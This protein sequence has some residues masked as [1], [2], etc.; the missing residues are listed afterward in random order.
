MQLRRFIEDDTPTALG[1]V[2][3]AFGDDAIILANRRVGEQ[4]EIIA[5][6]QLDESDLEGAT[7]PV[8][9]PTAPPALDT[10]L[11]AATVVE[12]PST[13]I[14]N[15]AMGKTDDL[16]EKRPFF[17]E[18]LRGS[19]AAPTVADESTM[20]IEPVEQTVRD[21]SRPQ[22]RTV[23]SVEKDNTTGEAAPERSSSG[24]TVEKSLNGQLDSMF[25][26]L[27]QRFQC[28]EVNLWG[29][30]NDERS[31]LLK[32]LLGL[33]LGARLAVSLAERVPLECDAK[34]GLRQVLAVLKATLP[35]GG[36]HRQSGPGVTL[37]NGPAGGGKTTVLMK[38]A[39]EH[40]SR[41]GNQSIVLVCADSQRVGAFESL[42]A[43]G[44]LLGVPV[45]QANGSIE[46]DSLLDAFKHMDL[47]LVDQ[48]WSSDTKSY[49][50]LSIEQAGQQKAAGRTVRQL[51]VLPAGLQSGTAESIFDATED[52][53]RWQCVLTHLDDTARIGELFSPLIRRHV[54]IA[55]W[56]D[57]AACDV[58]M[59]K[60]DASVLVATAVA[61]AKRVSRTPDDD[62][63]MSLIQ[64]IGD[65]AR[66]VPTVA[67]SQQVTES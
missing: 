39:R 32:Q 33:G 3:L 63:L 7:R 18:L 59:Q 44:R 25:Q 60:A 8:V 29:G 6:G 47:V 54:P 24:K 43:F 19:M 64:P 61:M 5:T 38:L 41:A 55:S 9:A 58:P 67:I 21:I 11:Q 4:V 52:L 30:R 48:A 42:Q 53:E 13:R 12:S 57:T 66:H 14:M 50:A 51:L 16:E 31:L 40:V 2:R 65:M 23:A 28:L 62:W 36:S 1:A 37:L 56:S 10:I 26:K 27:E 22:P 49:Q 17:E 35:I 20:A 46:L 15:D 45:V 34:D